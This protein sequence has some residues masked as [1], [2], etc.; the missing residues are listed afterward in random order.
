MSV[1]HPPTL[2]S[3]LAPEREGKHWGLTVPSPP[4]QGPDV[5]A[6]HISKLI[7]NGLCFILKCWF[8]FV[9]LVLDEIFPNGDDH[10]WLDQ[11]KSLDVAAQSLE[12]LTIGIEASKTNYLS[13]LACD[14]GHA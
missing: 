3:E 10:S 1:P 9:V 6:L 13:K 5:C 2:S 8:Q 11:G 7:L 4:V 12:L 14:K